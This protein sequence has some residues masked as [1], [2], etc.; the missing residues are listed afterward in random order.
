MTNEWL[1]YHMIMATPVVA[2]AV[3][4]LISH[5]F[6]LSRW[7]SARFFTSFNCIIM[8]TLELRL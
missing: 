4:H 3:F 2:D 6:S 7:Y 1:L 5:F 8:E